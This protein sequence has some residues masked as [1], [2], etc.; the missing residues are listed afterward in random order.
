[1]GYILTHFNIRFREGYDP[2]G[3]RRN[4]FFSFSCLPD[5]DDALEFQRREKVNDSF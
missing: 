5:F 4:L 3:A 1:M 2:K